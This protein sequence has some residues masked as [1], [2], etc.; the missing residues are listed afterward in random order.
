MNNIKIIKVIFFIWINYV[1]FLNK[2]RTFS[3]S[4]VVMNETFYDVM[5]RARHFIT[6]QLFEIL[7][8]N[9]GGSLGLAPSFAPKIA[10]AMET[11]PR[12][13][14]L[15]QY[16]VWNVLVARNRSFVQVIRWQKM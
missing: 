3:S 8:F 5:R 15:W 14:V 11:K 6:A 12:I 4:R 9:S 1:K 2:K 13:P 16:T 10:Y 7:Q